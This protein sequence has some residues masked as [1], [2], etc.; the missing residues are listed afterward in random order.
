VR[1]VVGDL[2][3]EHVVPRGVADERRDVLEHEVEG[4]RVRLVLHQFHPGDVEDLDR[5]AE[6]GAEL[7]VRA[8]VAGRAGEADQGTVATRRG[9]DALR[10]RRRQVGQHLHLGFDQAERLGVRPAHSTPGALD[11]RRLAALLLHPVDDLG[12]QLVEMGVDG[13]D[14]GGVADEL[15]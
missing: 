3:D 9:V 2:L 5:E 12:Q 4:C 11:P 10:V 8:Q 6:T 13:L 7:R 14:L 1:E 15:R